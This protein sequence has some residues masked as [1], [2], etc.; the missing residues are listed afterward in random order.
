M[1]TGDGWLVRLTPAGGL[2]PAQ[3]AGLA[4]AA[5]RLGNGLVEVTARG[6][7]QLRGLTPASAAALAA[8][9]AELGIAVETGLGVLSG[10]LAGLDPSEIA[11]PRPLAA[12]IRQRGAGVAGRLGPKVSVVVDGGGALHLDALPADVRLVAEAGG[13]WRVGGVRYDVEGAIAVAVDVLERLALIGPV[14][15]GRRALPAGRGRAVPIGRFALASG[16][17]AVGFGLPFGQTDCAVLAALA[18]AATEACSFVPAPGRALMAV[19]LSQ[20]EAVALTGTAG[21]LGLVVDP[22]DPRLSVVACSGAPACA[23]AELA[24]RVLAAEVA[25]RPELLPAALV[26]LSG[27]GKR[28]A[29]P[30]G[31]AVT[32]VGRE[33]AGDGLPASAALRSFVAEWA[34]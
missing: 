18:A 11:D 6:S 4:R 26:H 22:V 28:C 24:T 8:A 13:F 21:G 5:A 17:V 30:S 29:Q 19:G 20:E 10:P 31:P 1:L 12:A 27:C 25:A 32:F 9:V 3:L 15:G 2:T 16:K 23:S 14:A 7:L 34:G 33:L